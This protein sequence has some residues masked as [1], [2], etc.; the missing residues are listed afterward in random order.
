MII[1]I[2]VCLRHFFVA[3]KLLNRRMSMK[4]DIEILE[5]RNF[6]DL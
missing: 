2:L 6:Y 1:K 5:I 4:K 3:E